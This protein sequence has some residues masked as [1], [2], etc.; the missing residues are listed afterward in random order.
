MHN[1]FNDIWAGCFISIVPNLIALKKN[2]IF[3]NLWFYVILW[4][5]ESI[6]WELGRPFV[7]YIFNPFHKTPKILW[8]DFFAYM[9]GTFIVY[10]VVMLIIKFC[11][12]KKYKHTT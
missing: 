2:R 10:L 9:L 11:N 6:V 8:G 5:F 4:I 12:R 1:F 3:N 7:L